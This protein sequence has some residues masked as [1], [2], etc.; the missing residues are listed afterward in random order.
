MKIRFFLKVCLDVYFA[1]E[2]EKICII[3]KNYERFSLILTN[4]LS[5][6]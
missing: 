1:N 4:D 2:I 5:L 3:V 6:K